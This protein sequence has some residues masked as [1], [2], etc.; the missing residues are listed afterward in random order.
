[1][2]TG[3]T[4]QYLIKLFPEEANRRTEKEQVVQGLVGILQNNF[5]C[6]GE[7]DE[8]G[9]YRVR[10]RLMEVT[11]NEVAMEN[12]KLKT[13]NNCATQT[14]SPSYCS[15]GTEIKTSNSTTETEN[16]S[17]PWCNFKSTPNCY[18]PNTTLHIDIDLVQ[19]MC[20]PCKQE[21]NW[22]TEK[23]QVVQG[24]VGILQNHFRC[25]GE[26]DEEGLYRVRA[27]LMEVTA[28]YLKE[29]KEKRGL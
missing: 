14:E 23:E 22:R 13:S 12:K 3:C 16:S 1:M 9:L 25:R 11:A 26:T 15:T 6:R 7:T 2:E 21:A 10:A 29:F 28:K 17:C 8:E 20:E 27:R 4:T 18:P 24:L 5:R 19:E